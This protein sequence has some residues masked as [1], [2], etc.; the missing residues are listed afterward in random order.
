MHHISVGRLNDRPVSFRIDA[1]ETPSAFH[2]SPVVFIGEGSV[3]CW[4][5]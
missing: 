1:N 3:S 5:G 4:P 2:K